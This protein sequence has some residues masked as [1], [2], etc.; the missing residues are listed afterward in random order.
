MTRRK[1]NSKLLSDRALELVMLNV[2]GG[3]GRQ[4]LDESAQDQQ[5]NP[6]DARQAREPIAN[7]RADRLDS[8]PLAGSESY[9]KLNS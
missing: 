2:L 5:S 4:A 1:T 7:T 9:Q 3:M 6:V 8:A